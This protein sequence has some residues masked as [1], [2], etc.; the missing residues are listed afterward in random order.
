MADELDIKVNRMYRY[1]RNEKSNPIIKNLAYAIA[2]GEQTKEGKVTRII[3][4]IKNNIRYQ[5]EPAKVDVIVPPTRLTNLKVGDCE[6]ITLF[7]STLSGILG[8]SSKWKV[9]SQD[10]NTWT[11]I[12]PLVQMNGRYSPVD[13]AA[14][15]PLFSEVNYKKS[16]IYDLI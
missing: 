16:R 1:Y 15:V 11:H 5:R 12:Y 7:L 4:W 2:N 13:L 3:S 8:V 10:G 14:P 6:D 9:I